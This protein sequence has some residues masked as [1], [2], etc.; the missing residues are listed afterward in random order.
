[1]DV[2]DSIGSVVANQAGDT[3]NAPV[4]CQIA[5]IPEADGGY[6][7]IVLNLPGVGSCGDTEDE[8][9][10]NA[11]EAISAAVASFHEDKVE[12]PWVKTYEVPAGARTEWILV[13]A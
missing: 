4:R 13:N 8:A 9:L 1:M 6:S 12:I 11:R 7:A 3:R 2:R 10:A 5:V